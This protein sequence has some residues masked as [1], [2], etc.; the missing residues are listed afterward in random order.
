MNP[1]HSVHMGGNVIVK[2]KYDGD[3]WEP[4]NLHSGNWIF[5]KNDI[6]NMI[7]NNLFE[8]KF[9]QYGMQYGN[10]DQLESAASTIY[11]PYTKVFPKD[12][13]SVECQHLPQK[14]IYFSTNPTKQDI[15]C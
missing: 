8:T 7:S 2:S 3:I 10:C 15:I 6:K 11:F 14:Y 9:K 1:A 5:H 12:I 13:E 4:W